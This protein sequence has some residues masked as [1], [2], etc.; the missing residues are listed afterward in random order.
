MCVRGDG[1]KAA[2]LATDL[3]AGAEVMRRRSLTI[4]A[5]SESEPSSHKHT[6]KN[7]IARARGP[8]SRALP[9]MR[10]AHPP[11][12]TP[13]TSAAARALVRACAR[14]A[15]EASGAA[16]AMQT[17]AASGGRAKGPFPSITA[18]AA[19]RGRPSGSVADAAV[20]A[21]VKKPR[22]SRAKKAPAVAEQ[23]AP[24]A[25]API[26]VP[27]AA[28]SPTTTIT[29]ADLLAHLPADAAPYAAV[30]RWILFSDL[31][32]CERTLP[33]ALASLA[34][35]RAA[36]TADLSTPTGV[37][38]LG[39]FWH[40]RGALP[41][42][43]LLAV[44]AE[45]GRWTFP[46]LLIP[47]NHDQVDA[48]GAAHGLTILAAAMAGPAHVFDAPALFLGAL[49][50]PYRRAR[51]DLRAAVAAAA[52][53]VESG[54]APPIAAVFA[55]AD[56]AGAAANAAYQA[57]HGV[58]PALFPAKTWSGHYHKPQALGGGRVEYV[59]S[60]YQVSRGEA[61]EAKALVVLEGASGEGA[62]D[63][64]HSVHVAPHSWL[65]VARL[66]LDVGPR[67]FSG[68]RSEEVV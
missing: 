31:H 32:V 21:A 26:P 22:A 11:A 34:A 36:A 48:G 49:W 63:H 17:R 68:I 60:P 42:R 46:T 56:V 18:A 62:A 28:S 12:M 14:S 58:D 66:P 25:P 30:R 52:E 19:D 64:H 57:A 67:H 45:L 40:E 44:W 53:A 3:D 8:T 35:V 1:G 5:L 59:G 20:P 51:A 47:G 23:P 15:A 2:A 55:H 10:P 54:A 39:D 61:G 65:E 37:A 4:S 43:P 6:Q 50:L 38:F 33:S 16:F 27:P 9:G 41:L 29:P 24:R 7:K 13:A